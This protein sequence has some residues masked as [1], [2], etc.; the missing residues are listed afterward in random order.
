MAIN[1]LTVRTKLLTLLAFSGTVMLVG[2]SIS[3][4]GMSHLSQEVSRMAD[5]DFPLT[6]ALGEMTE[7]QLAQGVNLERAFRYLQPSV[8]DLQ[9]KAIYEKAKTNFKARSGLLVQSLTTA[10]KLTQEVK[11]INPGVKATYAGFLAELQQY[12]T[13]HSEYDAKAEQ[14]FTFAETSRLQQADAAAESM[15]EMREQLKAKLKEMRKAIGDKAIENALQAKNIQQ[16]TTFLVLAAFTTTLLTTM[17][18]GLLMAQNISSSLIIAADVAQRVSDGKL[19]TEIEVRSNDEV[20]Q[21]LS[22]LKTM[23]QSLRMLIKQVQHS[24]IQVTSSVTEIAAS[25]RQLEATVTEQVAST[26]EVAATARQIANTAQDLVHTMDEV[27]VMSEASALAATGGKEDLQ[28]M[29][30]TMRQ[31]AEST[32]SISARLG[33][34][35][36]KANNINCIVSTI[37]KVADQTNLLSLNA[38]IEAE[39]AG[40]YGLGF[41]VVA[42]EIRRLADQTAVATLDIEGMVRDMQSSVSAGVMEMDKFAKEVSDSVDKAREISTQFVEIINKV[43][44]LTPRFEA[45]NQGMEAQSH[46]AQQISDAMMQ[47]SEAS[48]QTVSALREINNALAHLTDTAQNLRHEVSR[49]QLT[50]A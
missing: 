26:H 49:Y 44:S 3:L 34:I 23:L 39:K 25:G 10:E 40:E 48:S 37:T 36:E 27:V 1:K 2:S 33:T 41:A 24:G 20:G 42:R 45:V 11:A 14:A 50:A 28:L 7:H 38:A 15:Q 47:L 13:M 32:R 43:Q 46:S 22:S 8:T 16:Q 29:E 18:L 17:A 30:T 9:A 12:R 5:T 35:S 21:V 6:H 31:L 4:I 19:D